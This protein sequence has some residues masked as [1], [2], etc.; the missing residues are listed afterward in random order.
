MSCVQAASIKPF[1]SPRRDSLSFG[2]RSKP[3]VRVASFNQSSGKSLKLSSKEFTWQQI[4]PVLKHRLHFPNSKFHQLIPVSLFGG[5]DKSE[6]DNEGSAWKSLEKAMGSFRKDQSIEDVLRQQIEKQE[7]Y[8]DGSTGGKPPR[9]GGGGGGDSGGTEDDG[10]SGILDETLQVVLATLGFIFL[11]VFIITGE[12]LTRLA[13]DYIKYLFGGNKSVR[14]R[15]AMYKWGRFYKRMTEK[16]EI[17]PYWLE[18]EII[19][20]TTWWD[21]PEK[22]RRL[23]NLP[24]ENSVDLPEESPYEE[25]PY[26]EDI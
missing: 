16:K 22:Y 7:F 11:Y 2:L 21:S 1:I 12:E 8:D 3:F 23:L 24:E 18:R 14:L 15:K 9:Q 26:D 13:K 20:T 17:D 10:L 4:T 19:N 6:G 5:K 25:P